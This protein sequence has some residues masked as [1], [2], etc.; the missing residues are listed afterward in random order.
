MSEAMCSQS[1]KHFSTQFHWTLLM[2][3]S[4]FKGPFVTYCISITQ[5]SVWRGNKRI[6]MGVLW[7]LLQSS[8][9][10][11]LIPI[12][13]WTCQ[14]LGIFTRNE[15]RYCDKCVMALG[16]V[17]SLAKLPWACFPLVWNK[18]IRILYTFLEILLNP[19]LPRCCNLNADCRT[20]SEAH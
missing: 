7:Y 19:N 9:S 17:Q 12:D 6:R 2:F 16:E 10:L 15:S 1:P 20:S 14:L 8:N 5:S 11:I 3:S 18:R 4:A 13:F